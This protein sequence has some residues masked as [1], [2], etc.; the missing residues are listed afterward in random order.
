MKVFG[1]YHNTLLLHGINPAGIRR[2]AKSNLILSFLI[3]V[4]SPQLFAD[5][6]AVSARGRLE[7]RDGLFA[8][9]GPSG[10]SP[11][12]ASLI[13][14]E[15]DIV[16]KGQLIAMLDDVGIRKANLQRAEA[17]RA[18][19]ANELKRNKALKSKR[20]SSESEYEQLELALLVA[21][22]EVA[23]SQAELA[24]SMVTSPI[25]GKVIAVHARDGE[26]VGMQGIVELGRTDQMYAIAEVYETDIGRL[27]LGQKATATS[28]A[29][30]QPLSGVIDRLGMKVGIQAALPTDPVSRIDAR[31]VEV[32]IKL[33]N[34]AMAENLT[35]LHVE[36]I[37]TP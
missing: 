16:K 3:T 9:A 17:Q 36:I 7:P 1:Q 11:V 22:A 28:P 31:V 12:V 14:Q 25:N 37:F 21:D 29:L 8:V 4:L 2:V 15:G 24:R 10:Y 35:N 23:Q 6:A 26:R 18:N 5:P 33:D 20:M 32:D 13:V 19:A 34:S 30:E 27:K